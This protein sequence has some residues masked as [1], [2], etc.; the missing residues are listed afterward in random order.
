MQKF[1]TLCETI[2]NLHWLMSND[3]IQING[4]L[5]K[6]GTNHKLIFS[7]CRDILFTLLIKILVAIKKMQSK[8][9]ATLA[10]FCYLNKHFV[11]SKVI[12]IAAMHRKHFVNSTIFLS[13]PSW[14]I[15]YTFNVILCHQPFHMIMYSLRGC[16]D[17]DELF[18]IKNFDDQNKTIEPTAWADDG[19]GDALSIFIK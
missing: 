14:Y 17:I 3:R 10:D 19:N 5:L 2:D 12:P 16:Y 8:R 6:W 1:N 18:R 4:K 15:V 13:F 11:W 7:F 9:K